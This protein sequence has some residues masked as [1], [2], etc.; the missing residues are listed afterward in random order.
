MVIS[1]FNWVILESTR[2]EAMVTQLIVWLTSVNSGWYFWSTFES[3]SLLSLSSAFFW[4]SS[5]SND[6][7]E[8][9]ILETLLV[10]CSFSESRWISNLDFLSL[11]CL[12]YLDFSSEIIVSY[13]ERELKILSIEREGSIIFEIEKAFW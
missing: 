10:K 9:L 13:S 2:S 1:L 5:A 11:P 7:M 12:R 4:L 8:L 6:W 3:S